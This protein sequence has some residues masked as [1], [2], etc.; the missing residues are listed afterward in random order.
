YSSLIW[1]YIICKINKVQYQQ[2]PK[3]YGRINVRGRSGCLKIGSN[4]TINYNKWLN[5]VGLSSNTYI[6][7]SPKAEI[8]IGNHVGLSNCLLFD[9]ERIIIEDH[10]KIGGGCQILDNDFHSLDYRIRKTDQDQNNVMS[11][12]III[13]NGAFI[14][15][16]SIILKGVEIGENSI[17]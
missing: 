16:G 4:V 9:R 12:V 15:T 1:N 2:F 14:G 17:V 3:V 10:V 8:I 11:K 13:R 6:C 7:L 5:P